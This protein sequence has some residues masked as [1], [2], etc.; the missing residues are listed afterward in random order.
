MS[1]SRCSFI[2]SRCVVLEIPPSISTAGGHF[3][4]SPAGLSPALGIQRVSVTLQVVNKVWFMRTG[5][6]TK[7]CCFNSRRCKWWLWIQDDFLGES[8]RVEWACAVNHHLNRSEVKH[9]ERPA[10]TL[11][12]YN[13]LMAIRR[14]KPHFISPSETHR[15]SKHIWYDG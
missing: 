6:V 13:A 3:P 9:K 11:K 12:Y 14:H 1:S 10:I 7:H 8:R 4:P 5:A 2:T 15:Q